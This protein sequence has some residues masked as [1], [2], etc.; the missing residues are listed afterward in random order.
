MNVQKDIVY[1]TPIKRP[2]SS[3]GRGH[4]LAIVMSICLAWFSK[5][6]EDK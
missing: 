2:P 1:L 3:S 5:F 4:I 6:D